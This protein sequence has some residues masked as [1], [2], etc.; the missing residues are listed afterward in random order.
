MVDR[1]DNLDTLTVLVEINE[2]SFSD[3]VKVLQQLERKIPSTS[4][5]IWAFPP[6]ASWLSQK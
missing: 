2:R 5:N 3:E 6:G 4:R 1:E